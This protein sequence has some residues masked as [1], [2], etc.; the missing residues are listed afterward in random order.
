MAHPLNIVEQAVRNFVIQW[1]SGL[2]PSICLIT[3]PDGSIS[4]TTEV[5]SSPVPDQM[6]KKTK[7]ARRRRSGFFARLRR[8][9]DRETRR[10]P[11]DCHIPVLQAQIDDTTKTDCSTMTSPEMRT[12]SS[13]KL[14]SVDIAPVES[15]HLDKTKLSVVTQPS[16]SIPPRII[17]HPTVINACYAILGKH[18]SNL[19]PTEVEQF[20]KYKRFKSMND[21]PIEE[22]VVYQPIG[23]IRTCMHCNNPT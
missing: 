12:L 4:V 7:F 16:L 23:G 13:T 21:D 9:R 22:N 8:R 2:Q 10:N 3:N 1:H 6:L 20:E 14:I 19:T 11:T 15:H 18:P 17:Y 5:D